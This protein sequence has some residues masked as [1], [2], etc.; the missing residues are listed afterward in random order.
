VLTE[1]VKLIDQCIRQAERV[2]RQV[3]V[4]HPNSSKLLRLYSRF[5][6]DIKNDPWGAAKY[7]E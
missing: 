2:Y 1:D 3:L 6:F 7:L 4:R 5:Q